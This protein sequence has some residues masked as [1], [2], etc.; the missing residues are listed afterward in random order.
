MSIELRRARVDELE[1]AGRARGRSVGADEERVVRE[2]VD[3]VRARGDTALREWTRRLDGADVAR[4]EVDADVL[5]DAWKAAPRRLQDALRAAAEELRGFHA[6]QQDAAS[7]G[8]NSAW[9]RPEPVR[10]AGCYVPGGR[11]A[12]PS[13]VLMSVIPAQVAG[14]AS[15]VVTSP[16]AADGSVHPI[17][18]SLSLD[19]LK[20][21]ATRNGGEDINVDF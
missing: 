3:D 16:P 5:H 2:I 17:T 14:V 19:V 12:Y 8:N 6:Y 21:L 11:A 18:L 4:T 9:L 1:R 20:A 10:R 7:R 13:T 15:I